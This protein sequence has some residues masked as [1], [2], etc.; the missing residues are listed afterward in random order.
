LNRFSWYPGNP[1]LHLH[2]VEK[3]HLL[4]LFAL[5]SSEIKEMRVA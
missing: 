4:A 3:L 2:K 5:H 1:L